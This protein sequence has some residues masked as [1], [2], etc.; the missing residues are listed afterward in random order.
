MLFCIHTDNSNEFYIKND[1]SSSN[2]ANLES[3]SSLN[4]NNSFRI[5]SQFNT[6]SSCNYSTEMNCANNLENIISDVH[7]NCNIE[8]KFDLNSSFDVD[9]GSDFSLDSSDPALDSDANSESMST[10]DSNFDLDID[11]IPNSKI[12]QL[13]E[14]IVHKTHGVGR[15]KGISTIKIGQFTHDC[16]KLEY[17][18]QEFI[19]IK[20]LDMN[21]IKKYGSNK[22]ELDSLGS[23]QYKQKKTIAI[24]KIEALAKEILENIQKR[25][26]IPGLLVNTNWDLY[27]KLVAKFE[28]SATDDQIKITNQIKQDCEKGILF[29][30]MI[31][32]DVGYGKT[33]IAIRASAMFALS[34]QGYSVV[35]IVPTTVLSSQHYLQFKKRFEG[36]DIEI[37][38]LSRN[39]NIKEITNKIAQKSSKI[40]IGTHAILH[41]VDFYNLG[42]VV[43]DEEHKFGVKQKEL[44]KNLVKN[45]NVISLSATP[46]PRTLQLSL[47][48]IKSFSVMNCPP[49]DRVAIKTKVDVFDIEQF[50]AALFFEKNRN[51]KSFIVVPH[52]KDLEEYY[53]LVKSFGLNCIM[54]HGKLHYSEI[55]NQID[56]FKYNVS[57]SSDKLNHNANAN[58]ADLSNIFK[59]DTTNFK[60]DYNV[61]TIKLNNEVKIDQNNIDVLISTPIIES[62]I[63]ILSANTMIILKAENFGLSQLYQLRGRVGRSQTQGFAYIFISNQSNNQKTQDRLSIMHSIDYLNAGFEIANH[64]MQTRGFGSILGKDQSGHIKDI[65]IEM[66]QEALSNIM[67]K[68][69]N[70]KQ[71]NNTDPELILNI[72][73][74]IPDSYI[75]NINTKAIYYNKI[76][77]LFELPYQEFENLRLSLIEELEQNFGPMQLHLQKYQVIF[78][79]FDL[80]KIKIICNKLFISKVQIVSLDGYNSKI[81]HK[82]YDIN[83]KII[84]TFPTLVLDINLGISIVNHA[85]VM[86]LLQKYPFFVKQKTLHIV[87][88]NS[89]IIKHYIKNNN[90]NNSLCI[91]KS[92]NTPNNLILYMTQIILQI[93]AKS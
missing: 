88:I 58:V 93:I 64:D 9:S 83:K 24:E 30:R 19:Y 75:Q 20:A 68:V 73:A 85:L 34:A 37:L 48:G 14:L 59:V 3:D 78:N 39:Q 17:K 21:L 22:A 87:E 86:R 29:D 10:Y 1:K 47:S 28:H 16:I 12:I 36:F 76:S 80:I 45:V 11:I 84:E 49:N 15:F 91:L 61:N 13:N 38:E 89:G 60:H 27:E 42:L 69:N 90:L 50:K 52:I 92:L 56:L 74:Y 43:I 35:I 57:A 67:N 32:G 71:R 31:C 33:E 8:P 53:N 82:N 77:N 65:G 44:L 79:I 66:Y 41:N 40:I 72:D 70:N 23:T 5:N 46:I 2:K 4:L 7:F 51:G 18:G 26:N 25:K 55:K 81:N 6:D 62:G 63:N 54:L